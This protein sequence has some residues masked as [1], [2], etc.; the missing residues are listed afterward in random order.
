MVAR[1]ASEYC[2]RIVLHMAQCPRRGQACVATLRKRC[3][4]HLIPFDSAFT[5]PVPAQEKDGNVSGDEFSVRSQ[6]ASSN[7]ESHVVEAVL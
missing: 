7:E 1:K 3:R 2:V 4:T 6:S 5:S